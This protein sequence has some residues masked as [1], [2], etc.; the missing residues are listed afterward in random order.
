MV[1]KAIEWGGIHDESE[2]N[3]ET[4]K[5]ATHTRGSKIKLVINKSNREKI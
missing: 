2:E 4:R 1:W 5:E 3:N